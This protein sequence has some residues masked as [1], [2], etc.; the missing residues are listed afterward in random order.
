M[1][2]SITRSPLSPHDRRRQIISLSLVTAPLLGA[3]FFGTTGLRSPFACPVHWLTGI[4]CPGCG[5]TRSF[6]AIARGQLPAA[7]DYHPFGPVLFG[8]LVL[9]AV[10]GALALRR[11]NRWRIAVARPWRRRLQLMA[12]AIVLGWYSA[13]LYLIWASGE[14]AVAFGRSPLGQWLSF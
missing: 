5:M 14:A 3:Y 9:W 6:V 7:V 10:Q 12:I 13:R 8:G 2:S 11:G 1:A 4:P